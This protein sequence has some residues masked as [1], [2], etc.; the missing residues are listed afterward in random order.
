MSQ[1]FDDIQSAADRLGGETDVRVFHAVRVGH[2]DTGGVAV[3]HRL[4][5]GGLVRD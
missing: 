5:F 4:P 3:N 1:Y 2:P